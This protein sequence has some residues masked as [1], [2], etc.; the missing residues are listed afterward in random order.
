MPST[1]RS[2]SACDDTSITHAPQPGGHHLAHERLQL[3]RLGRRPRRR[4]TRDRR[5]GRSPSPSGRSACPPPRRSRCTQIARRRLAVGAGDA[6]DPH[7]RGS[8]ARRTPR[9]AAPAQPRVADDDPR[10]RRRCAGAGCS[11]TTAAAPAAIACGANAAPSAFS[12]RSATN[13]M[14]GAT[15]RES[16]VTP[17]HCDVERPRV[18]GVQPGRSLRR[19]RA[20]E[21]PQQLADRHGCRRTSRVC[22]GALAARARASPARRDVRIER[23]PGAGSLLDHDAGAVQAR[24]H[25]E[26]RQHA[27]RVARAHARADRERP[28]AA[29]AA[30]RQRHDRGGV[31]GSGRR[32]LARLVAARDEQRRRRRSSDGGTPWCRSAASAIRWKIGRRD[33]CRRTGDTLCGESITTTIVNTGSRDGTKPTN[34]TL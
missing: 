22:A 19:H 5:C 33:R 2:A 20:R 26:P 9:R 25:A 31:D 4:R 27:Q 3:G 24:G 11:A 29:P 12:P 32:L 7:L 6:D 8:D 23:L 13:T 21:R 28:S 34:D 1:R 30:C 14:P 17:V 16:C 18:A 10:H 15:R